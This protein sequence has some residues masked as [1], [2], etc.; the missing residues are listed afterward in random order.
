MLSQTCPSYPCYRSPEIYAIYPF[1]S[2]DRAGFTSFFTARENF[3]RPDGAAAAQ[4]DCA[5]GTWRDASFYMLCLFFDVTY[6][7]TGSLSHVRRDELKGRRLRKPIFQRCTWRD[8][9]F[10]L[11][12]I[13]RNDR[14]D[15]DDPS[16]TLRV[17]SCNVTRRNSSRHVIYSRWQDLSQLFYVGR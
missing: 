9:N 2:F 7:T 5:C 3:H 16:A 14:L 12:N 11:N 15:D 1:S 4:S 17:I 13:C 8:T 6:M 10:Q